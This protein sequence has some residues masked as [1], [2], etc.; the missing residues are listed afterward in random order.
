MYVR[1]QQGLCIIEIIFRF[2]LKGQKTKS[3]KVV[4]GGASLRSDPLGLEYSQPHT[5]FTLPV[6]TK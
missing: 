2:G 3:W 4:V 6:T 1:S 5:S